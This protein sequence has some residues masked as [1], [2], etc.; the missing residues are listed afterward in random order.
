[1][2]AHVLH[3]AIG[4]GMT[5]N[6]HSLIR[7]RQRCEAAVRRAADSFS[8]ERQRCEAVVWRTAAQSE[9]AE[10]LSALDGSMP[11]P[12]ERAPA[13]TA[14]QAGLQQPRYRAGWVDGSGHTHTHTHRLL[15]EK[16][17]HTVAEQMG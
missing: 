5:R 3:G 17:G 9:R 16:S 11:A 7:K 1:M 15:A 13:C 2:G 6:R 8:R 14:V 10:G 12:G 4:A